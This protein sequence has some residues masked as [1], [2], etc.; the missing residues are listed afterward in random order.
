LTS[1]RLSQGGLF[2]FISVHPIFQTIEL[3][4][5]AEPHDAALNMAVDEWLLRNA[6]TPMLRVYRWARPALS[7]GYFMEYA[8]IEPQLEGREPVRR[9]TGGGIV[10][11]GADWT[12]SLI[13][14]A[15]EPFSRLPAAAS[16]HEIHARLV[17]ALQ[18]EGIGAELAGAAPPSRGGACFQ[19]PVACDVLVEA[20]KIAGAAQRRSRLG[21]LHQGSVQGVEVPD[22]FAAHFAAQLGGSIAPRNLDD[23]GLSGA[24]EI[25]SQ[26][27]ARDAWLR[28]F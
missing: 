12:C 10:L 4:R 20:R 18:G 25:A 26:R 6:T 16:Y 13:V 1:A 17:R 24:V 9:W 5:D 22:D 28:R 14:P 27:Y 2:D 23:A 8:E 19:N 11:H 3:L 21:M 7:F 15:S